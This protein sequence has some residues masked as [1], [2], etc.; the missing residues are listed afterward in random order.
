MVT[1][2]DTGQR[3]TDSENGDVKKNAK[4]VML[5]KK[6]SIPSLGLIVSLFLLLAFSSCGNNDDEPEAPEVGNG[7]AITAN[8]WYSEYI[9]STITTYKLLSF[10]KDGTFVK[11]YISQL[12][13][14]TPNRKTEKGTYRLDGDSIYIKI[15]ETEDCGTYSI[16]DGVLK[17][18][19]RQS[20]FSGSFYRSSLDNLDKV[21]IG[22]SYLEVE[23]IDE[24]AAKSPYRNFMYG[25]YSGTHCYKEISKVEMQCQHG[26]NGESNF[27]YLRFC[28]SNGNVSPNGALVVYIRP[29][30]EGID[31]IWPDGTYKTNEGGGFYSY[32]MHP[33][34]NG[35]DYV[36][37][38]S[39]GVLTIKSNGKQK[40]F[41]YKS[42]LLR[43][44]FEGTVQD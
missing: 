25:E 31:K 1:P 29:Y 3:N 24:I 9:G 41:E 40:V 32:T 30:Y 6:A 39:Y 21:T 18:K 34:F 10:H 28:G 26:F 15:G 14:Y 20:G 8:S 7:N 2:V 42:N 23:P 38:E 27:R 12:Q 37:R 44:H 13:G 11:Y 17:L 43:I 22:N 5:N 36:G 4:S 33:Y 35:Q 19:C 16:T